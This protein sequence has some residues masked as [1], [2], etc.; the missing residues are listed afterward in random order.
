M[1]FVLV[2]VGQELVQQAVGPLDFEDAVGGQEGREALLPVVMAAFD[3]AFG[4][5]GGGEAQGHAVE[6]E[7]GAQLGEGIGGV[8]VEEGME[9]HV[10]GQ[11]QAVGLEGAGQ[12]VEVSQQGFAWVEA[13]SGVEA[14]GVVQEVEQALFGGGAGEESVRGGVV[15]PQGTEVADLPALDGL[16]RF[17]VAGVRG[18]LVLLGPAADA[19]AVGF[20]LEAAVE[21]AGAST[22]GGRGLG[23]EQGRELGD[24]GRGPVSVVVAAGAARRPVIGLA[25]RDGAKIGV[26]EFVEAGFGELELGLDGSGAE[27]VGAE[28]GQEM[29]DEGSGEAVDQLQ[30]FMEPKVAGERGFFALKLPRQRNRATTLVMA[31]P[32]VGQT[33]GGAQV[34]S[35]QSLILR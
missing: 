10:K 13:G 14:G 20:K 6:V 35:P 21:F 7:G 18:E 31:R 1:D 2:G 19:G 15:L 23:G 24:D 12:E 5:W 25:L 3:F 30:F 22:V 4:L 11:G 9:V 16:G 29:A 8:G 17:F 33:S 34:A 32:A 27:L 28:L 26:V